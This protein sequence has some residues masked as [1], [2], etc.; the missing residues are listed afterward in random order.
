MKLSKKG[1]YA[2][3]AM[4]ILAERH[5]RGPTRTRDIAELERIPRKFLEQILLD[6]SRA[7]LAKGTRGAHGGYEVL[8]RPTEITL[9]AVV[10]A[11]DGPLAPLRCVSQLAHEECPDRDCCGLYEVMLDVRNAIADILE[12]TTLADICARSRRVRGPG[13][14]SREQKDRFFCP[15]KST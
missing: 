14:K 3:R 7:G 13:S 10:R 2:L 8:R 9:A 1:E 4:V 5:E 11:I 12:N 6:L 15:D